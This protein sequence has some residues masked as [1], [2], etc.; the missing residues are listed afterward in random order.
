MVV[1]MVSRRRAV[2]IGKFVI[3]GCFMHGIASDDGFAVMVIFVHI[4]MAVGH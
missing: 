3:G 2:I 4:V 1:G